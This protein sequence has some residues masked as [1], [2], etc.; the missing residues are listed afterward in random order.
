MIKNFCDVCKNEI[1]DIIGAG[2]LVYFEKISKLG[3]KGVGVENRINKIEVDICAK[4][5]EQILKIVKK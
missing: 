3:D 4:C 5:N 1:T 2:K